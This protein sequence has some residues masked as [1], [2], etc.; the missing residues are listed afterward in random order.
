MAATI[1]RKHGRTRRWA[2]WV[3]IIALLLQ[4]LLPLTQAVAAPAGDD[5]GFQVICT[6]YG[7]K[8]VS[9]D[10][11]SGDGEGGD[12]ASSCPVCQIQ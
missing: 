2:A 9:L 12:D 1:S 8:T 7:L 3:G 5:A 11:S 4:G 10:G 6:A